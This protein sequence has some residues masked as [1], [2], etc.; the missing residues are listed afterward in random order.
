MVTNV[1]LLRGMWIM[2]EVMQIWR[3][4]VH[5]RSLPSPKVCSGPKT[6]LKNSLNKIFLKF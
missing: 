4:E 5:G 3:Q 2:G 6:A 1:P